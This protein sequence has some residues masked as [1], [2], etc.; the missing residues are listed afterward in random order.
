MSD[1]SGVA[2]RLF[3]F[4]GT[5]SAVV[6]LA[7]AALAQ[8]AP[9]KFPDVLLGA[10]TLNDSQKSEIAKNAQTLVDRLSQA[11]DPM[12]RAG[13][14]NDLIA[15]FQDRKAKPAFKA[16]YSQTLASS[17][18]KVIQSAD[19]QTR[20]YAMIVAAAMNPASTPPLCIPGLADENIGVRYAASK[21]LADALT[22][23]NPMQ[24][25]PPALPPEQL[26]ALLQTLSKSMP[27]EAD[28]FVYQQMGRVLA[29]TIRS[30]ESLSA[31]ARV[32]RQKLI[33]SAAQSDPGLK[34]A[35]EV[36]LAS[37]KFLSDRVAAGEKP[38]AAIRE[39]ASVSG[40]Y[41]GYIG[42]KIKELDDDSL[43]LTAIEMIQTIETKAFDL[44]ISQLAP[45]TQGKPLTASARKSEWDLLSS[46]IISW[47][48][49]K[50]NP[51]LLTK[52]LNIPLDQL[53]LP[54]Q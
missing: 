6:W 51:G 38:E 34:T 36:I 20:L 43:R 41:L 52:A 42:T 47:V 14:K 50:D 15:P 23:R 46:D 8:D 28:P 7:S 18:I 37:H 40:L 45:G 12:A 54:P 13:A 33:A 16:A 35:H 31:A 5:L 24:P 53:L 19:P 1:M 21:A 29:R 26:A 22:P 9:V 4:I 17:L 49:A 32:L 30:P 44:A 3:K 11:G 27:A 39:L 2:C 25:P 48:G 10:E